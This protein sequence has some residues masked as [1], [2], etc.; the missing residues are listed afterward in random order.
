MLVLE[1]AQAGLSWRTILERREN[2]R[3]SFDNFDIDKI[4]NYDNKKIEELL[5]NP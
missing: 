5:N 3:A 1:G 2:Y 4:I